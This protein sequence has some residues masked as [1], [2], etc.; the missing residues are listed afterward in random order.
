MLVYFLCCRCVVSLRCF[1]GRGLVRVGRASLCCLKGTPDGSFVIG[2]GHGRGSPEPELQRQTG[3][4]I[5]VALSPGPAC[6]LCVVCP[7]LAVWP[8]EECSSVL[9][10]HSWP[11]DLLKSV[12]LC[13]VSLRVVC[14]LLKS[15]PLCCRLIVCHAHLLLYML[16]MYCLTDRYTVTKEPLHLRSLLFH[17]SSSRPLR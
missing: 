12:P 6:C 14:D 11:C 7:L 17:P 5:R 3:A 16:Y 4:P 2:A 1:T 10:V 9:C 15:V 13:C 8:A